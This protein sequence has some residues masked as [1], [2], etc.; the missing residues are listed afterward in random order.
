[1]VFNSYLFCLTL[2]PILVFHFLTCQ[3]HQR[4]NKN[5]ILLY[6][7][8]FYGLWNPY[9]LLL[10]FASTY[11]DYRC[12]LAM[13]RWPRY[14]KVFLLISIFTNIGLLGFFKYYNFFASS[15]AHAAG[16][17]GTDWQPPLMDVVLPVGLSFYTF[18]AL[19]YTIDVYLGKLEPRKDLIDV[20]LFVAYFPHLVAG[21]I[22]RASSLLPQFESPPR[23]R[24]TAIADGAL[25]VVIGLFM[26]CVVADNTAVRVNALFANW[27]DN[28]VWQNWSAGMLFGVQV[29]GD[30]AGYSSIAIGIARIT[31]YTIPANF[32]F[33]YG[34][35]GFSDFWRR[36]HISLSSWLRDYLYIPLGGSRCGETRALFNLMATMVLG[37][38]WHGASWMFVIWG[39]IHGAYLC[40]ERVLR[41]WLPNWI[42][43]DGFFSTVSS[44]A[45]ALAT[46]LTVSITWIPFRAG[47]I[48]QCLAMLRGL[49]DGRLSG[50]VEILDFAL[51]CAVF[52][53]DYYWARRRFMKLIC[54]YSVIRLALLVVLLLAL[55]FYS[56]ETNV[57]IYFQF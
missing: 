19:S 11:I 5:V 20:A 15:A 42:R 37:G 2:I 17:F 26:K 35:I 12:A 1:M 18:E 39:A 30:F 44:F 36:W 6:S 21:P 53:F 48:E 22:V 52:L 9:F 54:R 55:Y 16:A 27:R 28:S 40:A 23:I 49:F 57:F 56:G 14:R 24:K 50:E 25:M 3:R 41:A 4:L 8:F 32:N 46:Y 7:Y 43:G 29:Y 33:P 31:G 38:L 34:A 47:N 45:V 10:L 51:P 13:P